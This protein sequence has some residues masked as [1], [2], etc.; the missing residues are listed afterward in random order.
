MQAGA[1]PLA[2]GVGAEDGV[3]MAGVAPVV[4][5]WEGV[6]RWARWARMRGVTRGAL[7]ELLRMVLVMWVAAGLVRS[8]GMGS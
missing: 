8:S 1:E 5:L 7:Q 4:R 3:G 6:G 2:F